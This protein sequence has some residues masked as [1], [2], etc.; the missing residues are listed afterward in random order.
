MSK[1]KSTTWSSWSYCKV[2]SALVTLVF[3]TLPTARG[4]IATGTFTGTVSDPSGAF[5]PGATVTA[6]NEGTNV[7]A[8]RQTGADGIYT[9][10]DLQPGYYTL[11]A[12]ASG[13]RALVNKHVELT[14]GFTQRVDFHVQVGAVTQEVTV[15]GEASPVDTETNRLSELVTARQVQNLPLNGRNIFQLIQLA[16]GAVNTTGVIFEGAGNRGFYTVV[17]GTRPN[18]QGY[19]LDGITDKDLSG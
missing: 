11:K 16:P 5:I 9:I 2:L 14:V 8:S 12:E 15:E 6:I 3:W 17:N 10:P 19:L 18:M 4:Q 1:S 13:F 7:P